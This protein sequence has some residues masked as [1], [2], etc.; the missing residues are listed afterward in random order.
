MSEHVTDK[1]QENL[2][3]K[4]MPKSLQQHS[5]DQERDIRTS[6]LLVVKESAAMRRFKGFRQSSIGYTTCTTHDTQQ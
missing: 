1:F 4:L 3:V 5:H 6:V 2:K